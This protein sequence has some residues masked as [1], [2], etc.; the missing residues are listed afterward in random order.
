MAKNFRRK[1]LLGK[2]F[3]LFFSLVLIAGVG[4]GIAAGVL[5]GLVSPSSERV[6]AFYSAENDN[7]EV[8]TKTSDPTIQLFVEGNF[9]KSNYKDCLMIVE[10]KFDWKNI[11]SLNDIHYGYVLYFEDIETCIKQYKIL[12][13]KA[14]KQAEKDGK[15]MT[16]KFRFRGKALFIG[17]KETLKHYNLVIF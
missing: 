4:I 7:V 9:P 14:E 3:S 15:E 5:E 12:K 8:Y 16:Q 2:L 10:G 11:Q 1:S 6:R 13:E 17:D